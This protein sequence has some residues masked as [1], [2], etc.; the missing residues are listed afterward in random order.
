MDENHWDRGFNTL[1]GVASV[2]F[3][4]SKVKSPIPGYHLFSSKTGGQRRP[5]PWCLV[6]SHRAAKKPPHPSPGQ[7]LLC[8]VSEM[9]FVLPLARHVFTRSSGRPS[10]VAGLSLSR[11]QCLRSQTDPGRLFSEAQPVSLIGVRVRWVSG[12]KGQ[13]PRGELIL[14]AA[15]SRRHIPKNLFSFTYF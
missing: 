2:W 4:S 5:G 12:Q 7:W 10:Q 1:E 14:I 8:H 6:S 13:Q 15:V 9:F 3:I 11:W